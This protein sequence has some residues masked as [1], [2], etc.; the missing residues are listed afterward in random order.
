MS[1]IRKKRNFLRLE[2]GR[3]AWLKQSSFGSSRVG[4][5]PE[6]LQ[7]LIR[8]LLE[9][10]SLESPEAQKVITELRNLSTKAGTFLTASEIQRCLL[11][12]KFT[13]EDGEKLNGARAYEL[14]AKLH[15]EHL[16]RQIEEIETESRPMGP[17]V[18]ATFLEEMVECLIRGDDARR[19]VEIPVVLADGILEK[20]LEPS[21]HTLDYIALAERA[22]GV[23]LDCCVDWIEKHRPEPEEDAQAESQERDAEEGPLTSGLMTFL[24]ELETSLKRVGQELN[25]LL[26]PIESS[27]LLAECDPATKSA[28][29]HDYHRVLE[30]VGEQAGYAPFRGMVLARMSQAFQD[31]DLE[32][33]KAFA[34]EAADL[35]E[36]QA[37][38][39]GQLKLTFLQHRREKRVNMLR[40]GG[41]GSP[42]D[43]DIG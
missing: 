6:E 33:S 14:A 21:I 9:E 16:H 19:A 2:P 27:A 42:S 22:I 11:G 34:L 12:F 8:T 39:E 37:E 35:F 38:K 4:V 18:F 7:P 36:A 40:D 26:A 32:K 29:V 28:R 25:E 20:T 3:D 17:T 23:S 41:T 5:S 24:R 13:T 43:S 31:V 10:P 15:W 30:R 1:L